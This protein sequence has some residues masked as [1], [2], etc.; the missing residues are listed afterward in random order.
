MESSAKDRR[1]P[2]LLMP[3][4]HSDTH[5]Y[6]ALIHGYRYRHAHSIRLPPKRVR[7]GELSQENPDRRRRNRA[8]PSHGPPYLQGRRQGV[9]EAPRLLPPRRRRSAAPRAAPHRGARRRSA[10]WRRASAGASP[11]AAPPRVARAARAREAGAAGAVAAAV[12]RAPPGRLR[13]GHAAA[14]VVPG[15]R[16]RRRRA[17]LHRGPGVLRAAAAAQGVRREG[18]RRDLPLHPRARRRARRR[19]RRRP[20]R[21]RHRRRHNY[22]AV[23]GRLISRRKQVCS[24][25]LQLVNVTCFLR[26]H[27]LPF[28]KT[29]APACK[30]KSAFLLPQLH[31][32]YIDQF[33]SILICND[34]SCCTVAV[35]M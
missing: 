31:T 22:P 8:E 11:R 9:L 29:S 19:P 15:R 7:N 20:G 26:E 27:L 16:V 14:G 1:I 25:L 34:L 6:A 18:A 10:A 35:C 5:T 17:L 23:H 12:A 32:S 4:S 33:A 24:S 21:H 13:L 28:E 3:P 2:A 30:L